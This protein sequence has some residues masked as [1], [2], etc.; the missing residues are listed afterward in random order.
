MHFTDRQQRDVLYAQV[1][2]APSPT[3]YA[4]R[5]TGKPSSVVHVTV[6]YDG[7]EYP[8]YGWEHYRKDMF[9]LRPGMEIHILLGHTIC[10]NEQWEIH[11]FRTSCI[12]LEPRISVRATSL[13]ELEFEDGTLCTH[14]AMSTWLRPAVHDSGEAL[15]GT[16]TGEVID[17]Y[18]RGAG[19]F[20]IDAAVRAQGSQHMT[21]LPWV[22]ISWDGQRVRPR[23]SYF[24]NSVGR[25]WEHVR[26]GVWEP[27]HPEM[28][29]YFELF[30][31]SHRLGLEGKFD[32]L[33]WDRPNRQ[34]KLYEIKSGRA[35]QS[36][37]YP[38][39][40]R[41]LLV[42]QFLL[43]EWDPDLEIQNFLVYTRDRKRTLRPVSGHHSLPAIMHVRNHV[44]YI[45]YHMAYPNDF[46][47]LESHFL[48]L[49]RPPCRSCPRWSVPR[50]QEATYN[51]HQAH[52]DR[53]SYRMGFIS[54]LQRERLCGTAERTRFLHDPLSNR[55]ETHAAIAGMTITEINGGYISLRLP[56]GMSAVFR[57]GTSIIL[58]RDSG[59]QE[60]LYRGEYL[61]QSGGDIKIL[62][63][64]N[65]VEPVDPTGTW[66]LDSV[67]QV[68]SVE[69]QMSSVHQTIHWEAPR[70]SLCLGAQV[71]R[72]PSE[73]IHD[74]PTPLVPLNASQ[75][76]AYEKVLRTQD[77]VC[78][79]G[80]PGTGKTTTMIA[81][82]LS[83]AEQGHRVLLAA[84]TNRAVDTILHAFH[85]YGF[86]QFLRIGRGQRVDPGFI[87]QNIH[88]FSAAYDPE[89]YH[90]FPKELAAFKVF[91]GT[92][93]SI[94]ASLAIQNLDFD[95]AILDE[96]A[97]MTEPAAL[98]VIARAKR[99][100][101]FGDPMQLPPVVTQDVEQHPS[102][103]P[104][105][106]RDQY[107]LGTLRKSHMERLW[108]I[109]RENAPHA[110]HTL[111][112]Q[113]RAHPLIRQF[114]SEQFYHDKLADAPERA[115]Q[116]S[117][118]PS[119]YPTGSA[120]IQAMLAPSKTDD[121]MRRTYR[122]I[123]ETQ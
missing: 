56:D 96:A 18:L 52:D 64:Q 62:L 72:I 47:L 60:P 14:R 17:T 68:S 36:D 37:A 88:E 4:N 94:A 63:Y 82:A 91:A 90:L 77:G 28:P 29:Q 39:H 84:F 38:A 93:T 95:M 114:I 55:Q 92:T 31:A 109:W 41:Q 51:T 45:Q 6:S 48:S 117:P 24:K 15:L 113:Y 67:A 44:V 32:A 71:P 110:R 118:L 122:R 79:Q 83:L 65:L 59:G 13:G 5:Q 40:V 2:T 97:Q 7:V 1:R 81:C 35:P 34:A 116:H 58:H 49:S 54:T 74:I 66:V 16:M 78:V 112:I 23:W 120:M 43:Q 98:G 46:P 100:A 108:E 85:R 70:F 75:Q 21:R 22:R 30:C 89:N 69:S 76:A 12:V 26:D 9:L 11:V 73:P 101:Y 80:P 103:F 105:A 102:P 115:S 106:M 99:F 3:A 10:H 19:S 8:V 33:F 104:E 53:E 50:C 123:L 111:H 121:T 87:K 57:D 61:G 25:S 107:R 20:D 119:Q 42:Y 27:T 86:R